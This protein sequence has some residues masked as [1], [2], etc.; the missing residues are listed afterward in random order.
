M[1]YFKSPDDDYPFAF[2]DNQTKAIAAAIDAGWQELF[3]WPPPLTDA[4]I[5]LKT[6][7]E[8]KRARAQTVKALQVTTASGKT[9]DG[10]EISQD[11]MSRA[12]QA[13][14]I[15]GLTET[16]WVLADNT[17]ATVT[18]AELQEALALSMQAMGEV[19]MTPYQEAE[20]A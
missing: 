4:E 7:E 13:A 12:I 14:Q 1:R 2:P 20:A 9:F 15:T 5:A 19:W 11:R 18:L 8:A 3:D 16:V 17:P 6:R 10:D